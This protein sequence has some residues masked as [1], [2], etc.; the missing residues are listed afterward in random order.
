MITRRRWTLF[1]AIAAAALSG[2]AAPRPQFDAVAIR[3]S[4]PPL[5]GVY[6]RNEPKRLDYH[7]ATLLECISQA[8]GIDARQIVGPDWLGAD[9]F[10]LVGVTAAEVSTPDLMLMLQS[11]LED[12]FHLSAHHEQRNRP[13][14]LLVVSDH[15]TKLKKSTATTRSIR[16]TTGPENGF[17]F[18]VISIPDFVRS[19]LSV[20]MIHLDRPVIDATALEGTFDF[21]LTWSP[22]GAEPEGPSIFEALEEQLGLK[23]VPKT[24]PMDTLILDHLD[25]TPTG[26]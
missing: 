18:A 8:Y 10:T 3:R 9:R 14:Y 4:E 23:L 20:R 1:A 2:Q 16:P 12:R 25:R 13:A 5:D 21:T 19:F 15:G 17:S 7:N 22:A 11:A 24:M 6:L 26:N